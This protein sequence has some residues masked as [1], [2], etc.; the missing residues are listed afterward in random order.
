M[1]AG[2]F[3]DRSIAAR[4]IAPLVIVVFVVVTG[5]P[6]IVRGDDS[7]TT[8][9]LRLGVRPALLRLGVDRFATLEIQGPDVPVEA[10]ELVA[11]VGRIVHVTRTAPGQF[12]ARYQPPSSRAPDVAV[13]LV[14][15]RGG[16]DVAVTAI[17]MAGRYHLT[18]DVEPGASVRV[19]AGGELVRRAIVPASGVLDMVLHV[20]PG[21]EFARIIATDRAGN[22]TERMERLE[23]PPLHRVLVLPAMSEPDRRQRGWLRFWVAMATSAGRLS[24]APPAID[25]D[26][27]LEEIRSRGEGL[28]EVRVRPVRRVVPSRVI[29]RVREPN[30]V[31]VPE[32]LEA[33]VPAAVPSRIDAVQRWIRARVGESVDVLFTIRDADGEQIVGLEGSILARLGS[34]TFARATASETGYRITV[35]MPEHVGRTELLIQ[36]APGD[37]TGA[38]VEIPVEVTP[39]PPARLTAHV[40]GFV[41]IGE[42]ANVIVTALDRFGNGTPIRHPTVRARGAWVQQVIA[43]GGSVRLRVVPERTEFELTVEGDHGLRESLVLT[44]ARGQRPWALGFVA[45]VRS[46]LGAALF[47]IARARLQGWMPFAASWLAVGM[48]ESG[49]DVATVS[50]QALRS[51]SVLSIPVYARA[52]VLRRFGSVGMGPLVGVGGHLVLAQARSESGTIVRQSALVGSVSGALV[53]R[54]ETALGI[55]S[56][57]AGVETG[58]LDTVPVRGTLGGVYG[59]IGWGLGL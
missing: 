34:R 12:V 57:E 21:V 24:T 44:A 16:D 5:V 40:R 51:A 52:G 25:V 6:C 27:G 17:P 15:V 59:A 31:A 45:G 48:L 39:G 56:L 37:A 38:R 22:H 11:S 13:I 19:E 41:R 30:T 4:G 23:I 26:G 3:M 50:D 10:L 28:F 35:T 14:R 55:W 58:G 47:G 49:L 8:A 18:L 7:V 33:V 20:P 53:G 36:M 9:V 29:V 32:R 1:T 42:P 54:V 46:N 43:D 2:C